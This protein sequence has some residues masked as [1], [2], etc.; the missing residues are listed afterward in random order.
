[1][2]GARGV[3]ELCARAAPW[4][5]RGSSPRRPNGAGRSF[6]RETWSG[7]RS[8]SVQLGWGEGSSVFTPGVGRRG[9]GTRLKHG[10]GVGE[11]G[12]PAVSV[13]RADRRAQATGDA[14]AS[15][16]VGA[17]SGWASW[18]EKQTD[19]IYFSGDE[20]EDVSFVIKSK[21]KQFVILRLRR[22]S[23]PG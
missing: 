5:S 22:L 16:T 10:A 17:L 14:P 19:V 3:G 20:K 1:M 18:R 6:A 21:L 7:G 9:E 8:R 13:G 12:S 11:G 15:G 4:K 2:P 23:F